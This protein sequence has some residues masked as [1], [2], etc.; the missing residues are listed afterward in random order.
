M[1]EG[2]LKAVRSAVAANNEVR[3]IAFTDNGWVVLFGP[4]GFVR[5]N[6]PPELEAALVKLN[7]DHETISRVACGPSGQWVVICRR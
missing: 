2:V 6:L 4:N 1:D 7:A 3:S 5:H